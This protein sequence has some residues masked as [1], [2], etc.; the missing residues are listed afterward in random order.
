VIEDLARMNILAGVPVSR[1]E[2]TQPDV[3]NLVV[4]AATELT[5]D[6]DIAALCAGLTE[7]LS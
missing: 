5:T 3:Q 4:L 1:L 6:N 7:V 2:P